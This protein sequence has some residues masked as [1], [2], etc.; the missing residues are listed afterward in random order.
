MQLSWRGANFLLLGANVISFAAEGHLVAFAPLQ[1]QEL[2]LSDSG[3]AV[4][5]GLLFA[6]TTATALPLGPFWGVLAER[7]SRRAIILRSQVVLAIA[8]LVA[9]WAPDLQWLVAARALMGL[10]FGTGGVIVATQAMLTPSRQVGRAIALVQAAQPIAGSAGPPLGALAIPHVGLRSL[11]LADA[12]VLLVGAA[13]LALLLPEPQGGH[14][15][16]SVLRRVGEVLGLVWTTPAIRWSF[17]NQ[18]IA[19][20]AIA[21]I[22][23]YL[24]V[25]ITQVA[26]EPAVA[27]GWIF[28]A[29][30][31]LTTFGAWLL[32]RIADRVDVLR[33]Y[34]RSMLLGGG[35]AAALAIAPWLWLIALIATLRAFPTAFSR[36]LLFMHL[37][38][39]VPPA[40]QTGIFGLLPTAGNVGSLIFPLAAS[41]LASVSIAAAIGIGAL[42]HA[43]SAAAGVRLGRVR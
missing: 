19:R 2:G 13:A 20:G 4:W 3:V 24:P 25:R 5:S 33:L 28:G 36:P 31:A 42:S 37:A 12:V 41:G 9:A 21:V 34:W 18:A 30:G 29:Y 10:S 35:L 40:H 43:A 16:S 39:V 23:S 32:S 26:E 38:R 11:L 8:L 22:D 14:K 6:V 27:I 15:P 17:L 1:L 7:F